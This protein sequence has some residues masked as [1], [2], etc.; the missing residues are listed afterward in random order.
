MALSGNTK[1]EIGFKKAVGVAN[2]QYSNT[3][4]RAFNEESIKTA[5]SLSSFTIF[6]EEI[7]QNILNGYSGDTNSNVGIGLYYTD[8]VVEKLRLPLDI[9]TSTNIGLGQSQAYYAK[10]PSSYSGITSF[11]GGTLLKDTLGKLQIVPPLFGNG[12]DYLLLD[13]QANVIPKLSSIDWYLDPYNGVL[14][15]Q[16]PPQNF[17]SNNLRP[18]FIE[19]FIYAGK[20][21]NEVSPT[22]STGGNAFISNESYN[23]TTWSGDTISGATR[24]ALYNIIR[25]TLTGSSGGGN[26]FISNESYNPTTWSGDTIS[27]ATRQALYNKINLD[28]NNFINFTASTNSRFNEINTYTSNTQTLL[29]NIQTNNITG[30]TNTNSNISI[31]SGKTNNNLIFRTF[32][33][34]SGINLNI[35][36]LN[37]TIQISPDYGTGSTQIARGNHTHRPI[38]LDYPVFSQPVVSGTSID[39]NNEVTTIQ[40]ASNQEITITGFT[41]FKPGKSTLIYVSGQPI[42]ETSLN[43]YSMIGD[44]I[45]Y[46][47]YV[48]DVNIA[49]NH[50]TFTLTFTNNTVNNT[51]IGQGNVLKVLNSNNLGNSVINLTVT[52]LMT[53]N[54]VS[55][56]TVTAN[57][58]GLATANVIPLINTSGFTNFNT[59]NIIN[60]R[61][62]YTNQSIYRIISV[63]DLEYR[64]R[65][66]N[67]ISTLP[68]INNIIYNTNNILFN[69]PSLNLIVDGEYINGSNS[70]IQITCINNNT[71]LISYRNNI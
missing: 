4:A 12:Y 44:S 34:F 16:S 63:T 9:D 2:T 49:G 47:Y 13:T 52:T 3:V 48:G 11:S 60:N 59:L 33:G 54:Q 58:S 19:C 35:G 46:G 8:N 21:L 27:G 24:Q 26:A 66:N 28:N 22:G 32:T 6:G 31:L 40:L 50:P 51:I 64:F 17:D 53:S 29:N 18:G 69:I 45:Y 70:L 5:P 62:I 20:M 39:F 1:A 55:T 71:F 30:S 7:N 23:P 65:V 14:F 25:T 37:E 41:N 56:I 15:I 38:D 57:T 61:L 10:L 36:P 42:T 68:L 67:S 43:Y